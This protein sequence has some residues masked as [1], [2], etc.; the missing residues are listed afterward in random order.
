MKPLPTPQDLYTHAGLKHIHENFLTFLAEHDAP[1]AAAYEAVGDAPLDS[2][3]ILALSPYIED[4]IAHLFDI[5][6]DVRNLQDSHHQ[7]A[8]LS[9]IKRQFVQRLAVRQYLPESWGNP[10]ELSSEMTR[11]L[12]NEWS[13]LTFACHVSVWLEDPIQY[14]APLE[15]AGK[16]AAWATKTPEGQSRHRLDVLFRLPHKTDYAHL[17]PDTAQITPRTRDGFSLTDPGLTRIEALDQTG[18]CIFCHHQHKDSCSKGMRA[19]TPDAAFIKN[20]LDI[21]LTGCP[22][23]QKISEMNEAKNQGW[24]IGALAIITLDNPMVAG[25]GHRICNDCMKA[26]IYQKQEPVNIPGIE[27]QILQDVL[28]LPW[29]FEIYSLLTR[30]NPLNT[31]RPYPAPSS[32][33]TVMVVG[34]GPAGYTLAHHLMN[35]GHQVIGIDGVKIEPDDQSGVAL[36]GTR[37]SFVLIQNT[38]TLMTDI[39]TRTISGFGGVSE[40]GITSR[41]NKNYLRVIRLL[42]ERRAEFAL[43]GGV[44]FGSTLTIAQAS[45]LGVDHI[46]LCM[47]AGS[48]TLIPMNNSL[49]PGVRQASDFLMALQLTGASK[50]DSLANL[51]VELPAVVIG[52]GL[53]AIDTATEILAYYPVQVEKFWRQHQVI[54]QAGKAPDNLWQHIDQQ[55]AQTFLEHGRLIVAEREKAQKENRAPNFLPLLQQ[56]GGVTLLYRRPFS[57][58]PS[59]RLNHEEVI[60]AL[61]EG[62]TIM[63][64]I[65]PR[66]VH[67]DETGHASGL[68]DETGK[69]WPARSILIAAGTKPNTQICHDFPGVF[70]LDGATFQAVDE[71]GRPVSPEKSPK[72]EATYVRLQTN[73]DAMH[74]SMSFFGDL[75]PSFAGNVVK[76]MASAKRGYLTI[77]RLLRQQAPRCANMLDLRTLNT[78]L[79]PTVHAVNRLTPTIVEVVIH[80][81]LAARA[82][83]PGQFFRVQNYEATAQ[84]RHGA[85]LLMEGL[86]LTGAKSWSETGLLSTIVL[87][88]GGSSSLCETLKSG[89][90][91]VCMGPTGEPTTLPKNATVL[92]IGGG[93]GNAVLFSIGQ[94]LRA[95]GT[96]VLYVAGYKALADRYKVSE[97]EAAAD[98]ILWCCDEAPGFTPTRPQDRTFVGNIVEAL[99]AYAQDENAQLNAQAIPLSTITHLLVIGSDRMMGAVQKARHTVLQAYLSPHHQAIGSINAP[100]QCMMKGICAQCLQRQIDPITGVETIVYT[101]VNQDQPLDH[102]DFASLADR[103]GQNRVQETLTA[104]YLRH[105]LE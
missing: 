50:A 4:Y 63:D 67:V 29:G 57:S 54:T 87:E 75:H 1:L 36:D 105:I 42:L 96:R 70:T 26:C 21:A 91:I 62:I 7:L 88:M 92:L 43:F 30:W 100:M 17:I 10:E 74:P 32:G 33:Y 94:A 8:I 45:D 104:A 35:D 47:G 93:L 20:P 76:A 40:Y 14:A 49:A 41:W 78:L 5:K 23:D 12:G 89:D 25:T 84:H 24:A 39:N 27:S 53:T 66:A 97:I 85:L 46:A 73:S 65:T 44:R 64:Q 9:R 31:A 77:S 51:Q 80:A 58:A 6:A 68:E 90:P 55:T 19:K 71:D 69:V 60:K 15:T 101:C 3:L 16:Y 37:T 95:Q 2:A 99:V 82:F 38:A 81:P 83:Q 59:Y 22:L 52:G 103:L 18:Y 86:A 61:E 79:R 98:Q 48:P 102:V 28:S 72:P 56:W 34:M 11:L 13:Q